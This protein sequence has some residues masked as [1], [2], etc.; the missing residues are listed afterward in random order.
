MILGAGAAAGTAALEERS[1][2]QIAEDFRINADIQ[3]ALFDKDFDLYRALSIT[4]RESRVLAAGIVENANDRG[5]ALRRIWRVP[6]VKHV[7][8]EIMI[9]ASGSNVAESARDTRIAA[10][11]RAK[12]TL[13]KNIFAVNYAIDAVRGVVY[14]MGI[15]QNQAEIDRVIQSAKSIKYVRAVKNFARIKGSSL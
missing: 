1:V 2:A 8:N 12:I 15:A 10:E 7:I 3:S 13:D 14:I 11:L 6:G 4:V 9:D 5:E